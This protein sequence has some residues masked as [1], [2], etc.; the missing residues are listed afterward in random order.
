MNSLC[1][2][3]QMKVHK[4]SPESI[5]FAS[6]ACS[7]MEHDGVSHSAKGECEGGILLGVSG[8]EQSL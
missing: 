1:I 8:F 3:V 4:I 5:G 2:V 6:A 7:A